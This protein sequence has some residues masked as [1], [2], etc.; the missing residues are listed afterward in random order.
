[1][2]ILIII[3]ISLLTV[4]MGT[5]IGLFIIRRKPRK[6]PIKTEY[7]ETE[8][9]ELQMF[10]RSKDTWPDALL[11]ADKLLDKALKKRRFKGKRMGE[12]LV[13]A[14]RYITDN[15]DVWDAHNLV[16]KLVEKNGEMPLKETQV[17]EALISF[18]LALIDL[19][20]LPRVKP[21]DS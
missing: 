7:F 6:R 1:M 19:E 3:T 21:R 17:K 15:D 12:R 11:L 4:L 13:S 9:R 5:V 16:K 14:Q 8:W 10:C 2:N 18:R 20:A